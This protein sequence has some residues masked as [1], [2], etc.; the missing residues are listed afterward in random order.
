VHS[1]VCLLMKAPEKKHRLVRQKDSRR[2]KRGDKV[3]MTEN[4]RAPVDQV[5]RNTPIRT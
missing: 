3:G 2:E 4:G 1:S 5:A